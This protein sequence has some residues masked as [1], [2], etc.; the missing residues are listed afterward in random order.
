MEENNTALGS[1]IWVKAPYTNALWEKV[2]EEKITLGIR[3][4]G[5]EVRWEVSNEKA[6][7]GIT[8]ITMIILLHVR[9]V[10]VIHKHL[11]VSYWL[12][13][14]WRKGLLHFLCLS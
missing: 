11:S 4:I 7:M 10:L 5:G 14:S 12:L 13:V 8:R 6:N 3:N 2:L 9:S 1:H